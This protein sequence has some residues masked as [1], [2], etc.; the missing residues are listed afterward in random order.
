M[1]YSELTPEQKRR[2]NCRSYAFSYLRRG[3][4]QKLTC[5]H[6]G[7]EDSQMHHEDYSK[8]LEVMWL[9]RICHMNLHRSRGDLEWHD[10]QPSASKYRV[11]V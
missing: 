11:S 4:L 8:P 9:C 5:E 2:A 7:S 3:K 6:C 10:N 1:K